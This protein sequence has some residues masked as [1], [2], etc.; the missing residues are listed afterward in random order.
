MDFYENLNPGIKETSSAESSQAPVKS[1]RIGLV[2][3]S[4]WIFHEVS[5]PIVLVNAKG[6]ISKVNLRAAELLKMEPSEIE[7]KSIESFI[8]PADPTDKVGSK[9]NPF[10]QNGQNEKVKIVDQRGNHFTAKVKSSL[11]LKDGQRQA[12]LLIR[13]VDSQNSFQQVLQKKEKMEAMVASIASTFINLRHEDVDDGINDALEKAG[14]FADVDR[15]YVFLFSEDGQSTSNTHEWCAEGI[16]PE[17]GN[18]QGIGRDMIP[19]WMDMIDRG[20]NIHIPDVGSMPPEMEKEKAILEAQ[21]IK[22]VLAFPLVIKGRPA[23]FIGFD[24]VRD[25]KRWDEGDIYLLETLSSIIANALEKKR[26]EEEFLDQFLFLQTLLE[27]IPSPIFYK[28]A[29]A[30]YLGCNGAFEEYLGIPREDI[31]GKT[32]FGVYPRERADVFYKMDRQLLASPGR[33]IYESQILFADEEY[34]DVIFNKATFQDKEGDTAGLVGVITDVTENKDIQRRLNLS[35]ERYALAA[36]AASVGVW[37]WDLATG[38]F[39]LDPIIKN[40]LGYEDHEIPNDLETWSSYIHPDDKRAVMQAAQDHIDGKTPEYIF[41]HRMTHKDGSVR[42]IEVRGLAVRDEEGAVIRMAGTDADITDRVAAEN[43]LGESEERFRIAAHLASDLIYEIDSG[44]GEM[45]WFGDIDGLLGYGEGEFPRRLPE[46]VE[47]IHPDDRAE[48]FKGIEDHVKSGAPYRNE[49]RLRKKNG[50]YIFVSSRGRLLKGPD[51]KIEKWVGLNTDVTDRVNSEIRDREF[52]RLYKYTLDSVPLKLLLLDRNLNVIIANKRYVEERDDGERDDGERE[53][54]GL[55]IKDLF[56]AS[57][58]EE[59]DLHEKLK[60]VAQNGGNEFLLGV[61]HYSTAHEVKYLNV[62]IRG[63]SNRLNENQVLLAIEDV[64]EQTSLREQLIQSQKLEAIG[65]LAG[66]VAHDF[67]NIMTAI[68]GY[69]ELMIYSIDDDD[70]LNRDL[71]EIV[72]AVHRA[73][74]MTN[75]LLAFSRKQILNPEVVNL[76]SLVLEMDNMLRRLIGENVE[77]ILDLDPE[78]GRVK[79][80]ATQIQ[81]A[82]V[83]LVVNGRDAMPM[84]GKLAIGTANLE[85]G[86]EGSFLYPSVPPGSYVQMAVSDDGEGMDEETLSRIFDPFFTTK[87]KGKGTGLGLSSVYGIVN[88]SG[89]RIYARSKEGEGTTFDI[90]LPRS[91]EEG[92]ARANTRGDREGRGGGETVLLV[93]DDDMVRELVLRVLH[94]YGYKVIDVANGQKAL[95]IAGEKGDEIDILLTDVIMPDM[96]GR[97]VADRLMSRL[98]GL[99]VLFM[100]GYTDDVIA[101]HGVLEEGTQL[102]SK[103]FTPEELAGRIRAALDAA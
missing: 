34:H 26:R 30:V 81:M 11:V 56:P 78:L 84:G 73:T 35:Q 2:S 97:E 87:S 47:Y 70:P 31:I 68:M 24:S 45:K 25:C 27:T 99:K 22:S 42:W 4:D 65:R 41:R 37:D 79:A 76:N 28:D 14:L 100:S 72:K 15:S 3:A 19:W 90:I 48:V 103:P 36:R 82:L 92:S 71:Q 21:D 69:S 62:D 12:I 75:Q 93:E 61:R 9:Y 6:V 85:I 43:A 10:S 38:D 16:E 80:D 1:S 50:E 83:N 54:A 58:L 29:K 39:F 52:G 20:E 33:Q 57:L 18:L 88:Q 55:N 98:C 49:Y 95:D 64:T 5:D 8:F 23:G 101:K 44:N 89:G 77:L 74:S 53:V 67:N 46:I 17:I 51:G 102:I 13:V 94:A 32:V 40:I 96:S 63:I 59:G 91:H 7:G 86:K 66:G 60:A